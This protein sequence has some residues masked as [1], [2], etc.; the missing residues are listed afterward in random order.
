M[1]NSYFKIAWRNLI[2]NKIYSLLILMSL[3]TGMTCAA[4]LWLYVHDELSFD[5]F[6]ANADN[7]YRLTLNMKWEENEYNLGLASAPFAATLQQEY[8][9]IEKSLRVKKGDQLFR[10]GEKALNVKEMICAD[11]TLFSFF[12]YKFVEGNPATALQGKNNIV[13]TEKLALALFNKTSGLIGKMVTVKDNIPFVVSAV[14]KNAPA[15]HHLKFDAVLPYSNEAVSRVRLDKWDG[16]NTLT[17]LLLNKQSDAARI[18]NKLPAFYRKYIAESIGDTEG[19]KVK[20]AM[21]L[22]PLTDIHLHSSHL[23]GEENGGTMA[24]IYTFSIIGLFILLIAIVNYVNLATARSASRGKEIGVRKVVGSQWSQL[25]GQ[26]LSESVLMAFLALLVSVVLL[27][28]L[29]PFFNQIS[30]KSLSVDFSNVQTIGLLLGFTLLTGLISGIYPAFILSRFKPVSVLKGAIGKNGSGTVFRQSLVVFQFFISIVMIAGTITVYRQL[31]YM[32]STELGFNQHQVISVPLKSP[33]L[34]QTALV[35]KSK[36]LQNPSIAHA[37]LTNGSIGDQLNNKTTFSFYKNGTEQ[38]I[39]AEYFNVDADF[40]DVLQIRVTDGRN[41]S[42]EMDHDSSHSILINKAMMKRLGWKNYREGL[43]EI[44]AEKVQVTGVISDFHLRSLHNQIEPLVLVM[45]RNKAENLLLKVAGNNITPTLNYVKNV[46]KQVNP[47]QPFEYDFLD[48]AFA[49]QYR[50]DEQKSQLFLAFSIIAIVVACLGL[51]GL[52]TFTAEQRTKEIGVRKV[53]GASVASI[54]SLLSRE[55][56]KLV[57]IAIIVAVPVGWYIMQVWL[58]NFAYKI[59]A[60]WWVFA[61]AGTISILIALLTVSFQSIR[62][63]LMNPVQSL[64]SE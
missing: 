56:L 29:L 47:G 14:I 42:N 46:F 2:R 60:E 5:R 50:T 45:K 3:A 64:K 17:Y 32:R 10:V 37:A 30:G 19:N 7:I 16:F 41:F 24:Y 53:L 25:V 11:S 26:F 35:L 39:S 6:H 9:E 62:A 58:G 20:F 40:A 51:F 27:S 63:A 59:D 23:M 1:L 18:E 28:A 34:Q 33:S 22:Q 61:L 12:D 4:A 44:D 48:Q 36:L 21:R 43:V 57:A 38:S 54:V 52:A 55:F 31:Q 15:N 8:P 13:L 49:R